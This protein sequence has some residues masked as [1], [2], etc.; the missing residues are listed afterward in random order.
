VESRPS[1]IG[2]RTIRWV[3][4]RRY[5]PNGISC[6]LLGAPSLISGPYNFSL[7]WSL[8][9][10]LSLRQ[11]GHVRIIGDYALAL[12]FIGHFRPNQDLLGVHL[13][14]IDGERLFVKLHILKN[15]PAFI[16][17]RLYPPAKNIAIISGMRKG[18]MLFT[19]STSFQFIC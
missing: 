16:Y 8:L 12:T 2:S 5:R 7:A 19:I 4:D 17:S 3:L 14:C 10:N 15:Q 11:I 13:E 18:V 9:R 1:F 6:L